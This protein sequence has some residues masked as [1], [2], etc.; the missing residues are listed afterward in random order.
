MSEEMAKFGEAAL[1]PLAD[2]MNLGKLLAQSGYFQDARDMAQA[3]VKVLAGRELGFGPIASMTGIYIVKGRVT[4]SANLIAAA[5]KRSGKYTYTVREMT[6]KA[7]QLDFL[8]GGKVL[9]PSRFTIE[10]AQKAGLVSGENWKHYPRNMLF[11][12]ALSNG[13]KWYTPD[14]FG[15]PIYTP[16]ELGER[17]DAETGEILEPAKLAPPTPAAVEAATFEA[18]R[19]E[20]MTS[21]VPPT[22]EHLI[23]GPQRKRLWAVAKACG[24]TQDDVRTLLASEFSY[25]ST[26]AIEKT[27]YEAVIERLEQGPGPVEVYDPSM[28]VA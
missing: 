20:G 8:E 5:I 6:D 9:G 10:D 2:T 25:I 13:A 28:D 18:A 26:A 4:L 21:D 27:R 22:G 19:G 16:D 15:G 3:V 11:A 17:V 7:V 24:W 23:T 12:R 14:V 1:V